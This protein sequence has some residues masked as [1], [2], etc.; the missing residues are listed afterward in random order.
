MIRR[1]AGLLLAALAGAAP[2]QAQTLSDSLVHQVDRVFAAYD[3]TDAPGCALGIYRGGD[4]TIAYAR[5]YGMANLEVGIAISPRTIFDLGSTSKQFTALTVLLL[6]AEGRLRLDDP[7]RTWLPEL[8]SWAQPITVRHL[9]HHSSGLRDYLTLMF[10]AGVRFDDVTD[11][12][13]ALGLIVRQQAANFPANTEYLYSN[14]GYFLL[15]VIVKR[16]TGRTL[17]QVAAERIFEPLGMRH[18]HYHDDHTMI[19]PDRATGYSPREGGGGGYGIEMS[20]FEQT[21]DGSVYTSVEELARWDRNFYDGVVGGMDLVRTQQETGVLANGEHLDYAAGLTLGRHRGQP[22]VRHGGSWAGYRAEL[23]R[24]PQQRTSVAVLCNRSDA[25]PTGLAQRV[26]GVV[27]AEALEP[28]DSAAAPGPSA[29][30]ALSLPR[31]ILLARAGIW[32]SPKTGGIRVVRLDGNRLTMGLVQP[33]PL[34]ALAPARFRTPAGSVLVFDPGEARPRM[35]LERDGRVLDTFEWYPEVN[36]SPEALAAYA[37]RYY[38]EELDALYDVSVAG[39]TL[40]ARVRGRPLLRLLPTYADAFS[41]GGTH[42]AF[43]RDGRRRVTGFTVQA[44]RVRNIRFIRRE[45]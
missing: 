7:V 25:D 31:E 33:T 40:V 23:L 26:A 41:D 17:R 24:F 39:D 4:G 27:L 36:P 37:G 22:T 38:A 5:G 44:G 29:A 1:H 3:R 13:D 28:A 2:A 42:V 11:D 16:I 10:L 21:G 9:V 6:A 34:I 35:R 14:T 12:E 8:G 20:G 15:S 30:P 32:V 45:P 18:T 19:V 43:T